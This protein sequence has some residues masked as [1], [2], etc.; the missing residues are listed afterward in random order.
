MTEGPLSGRLP[1]RRDR[2]VSMWRRAVRGSGLAMGL[3]ELST[4]RFIELSS[5]AAALLGTTPDE[6]LGLDYLSVAERP[7][8]AAETFRLVREGMLD[9][10]RARRRFRCPDG[11][12]VE[13]ESTGW[14]IRSNG[15]PDLGLWMAREVRPDTEH[16]G[17][18]PEPFAA[19]DSRPLR[20]ELDGVQFDLDYCWQMVRTGSK[21]R[22]L[23]GRPVAGLLGASIIELTHPDDLA[24]LLFAFA[25]ATT[26]KKVGVRVRLRHHSGS[27]RASTVAPTVSEGDDSSPF[28]LVVAV[29]D[30]PEGEGANSEISHLADNLRR[31]AAQIE[32]VGVSIELGDALQGSMLTKLSTRQWE[33]VSRLARGE[34]VPAIADALFVSPSTVRNHLTAI[35]RKF[36]VHSQAELLANLRKGT[37]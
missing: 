27:W 7:R 25:R 29:D 19:W 20:S 32:K 14:A 3:A 18:T 21:V 1:D 37:H 35:Y 6:G 26:E 8:E 31:I 17:V 22:S 13:V 4:T 34:R 36:G 5:R 11:S 28:T 30:G 12:T 9:G 15:G 23:L 16:D 10:L 2:W 33:I 24:V